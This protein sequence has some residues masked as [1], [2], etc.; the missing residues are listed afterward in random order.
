[1]KS[2]SPAKLTKES[3]IA[4]S[5]ISCDTLSAGKIASSIESI[6]RTKHIDAAHLWI[7]Q[8][9]AKER[10]KVHY[11]NTEDQAADILT[12]SLAR[13]LFKKFKKKLRTMSSKEMW[14]I[15]SFVCLTHCTVLRVGQF[16]NCV[17]RFWYKILSAHG[18]SKYA[19]YSKS[20]HRTFEGPNLF[21]LSIRLQILILRGCWRKARSQIRGRSI[22]YITEVVYTVLKR[23]SVHSKCYGPNSRRYNDCIH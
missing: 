11:V 14:H 21:N 5:P 15:I 1:M 9:V 17:S 6:A 20:H 23:S 4:R 13:L 3:L 22:V 7:Q 8:E 2:T 12:K 18:C 10:I 19:S 16:R